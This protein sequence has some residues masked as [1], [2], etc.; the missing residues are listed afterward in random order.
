MPT[1]SI[2]IMSQFTDPRLAITLA[3]FPIV[4]GNAWQMFRAGNIVATI[5]RY[6]IFGVALAVIL[7]ATSLLATGIS[8]TM[9]IT[10]LGIMIV[11]FSVTSLA[12][13]PPFLPEKYDRIGQLVA[14]FLGGISGGLTAIWGPPM[15]VY[16]LARRLDKD[17]FVR[18]SGVLLLAGSIPLLIG[19]IGNGL[20]DG[21][22]A[23]LSA[24]LVIPTLLGFT[25]GE[26]VRNRLGSEKFRTLV[27]ILFLLMGL[28]LLRRALF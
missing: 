1:T 26:F 2:G 6:W 4:V 9:L 20:L 17:E 19:Y 11:L 22:T 8:T 13:K 21:P 10:L 12:I 23:T 7:L 25:L 16:F 3:V 24:L 14:G 18:A 28:N 27:L 5:R 15:I